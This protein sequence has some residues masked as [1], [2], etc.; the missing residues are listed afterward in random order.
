MTKVI[1]KSCPNDE[2]HT[3][4]IIFHQQISI[5]NRFQF[6]IISESQKFLLQV[7]KGEEEEQPPADEDAEASDVPPTVAFKPDFVIDVISPSR[8]ADVA[9][10][11]KQGFLDFFQSDLQMEVLSVHHDAEKKNPSDTFETIRIYMERE[12]RKKSF[13]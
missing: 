3:K 13:K 8:A 12:G 10:A 7:A 4:I 6:F 9:D 11:H 1:P 2:I 5:Q